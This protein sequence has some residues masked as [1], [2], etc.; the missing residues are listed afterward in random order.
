MEFSSNAGLFYNSS[1]GYEELI[2]QG[3]EKIKLIESTEKKLVQSY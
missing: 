2:E 3:A 1:R